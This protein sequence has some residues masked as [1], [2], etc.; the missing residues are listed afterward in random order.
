MNS[1]SIFIIGDQV[2][3]REGLRSL[4]Q[5][6]SNLNVLG[7]AETVGAALARVG[8]SEL[9]A[10]LID[11]RLPI[12][13]V[14]ATR[15]ILA[16]APSTHAIVL[17][18]YAEN[19]RLAKIIWGELRN[20]GASGLL[21]TST[22]ANELLIAIRT[23]LAGHPVF[24]AHEDTKPD[25]ALSPGPFREQAAPSLTPRQTQV[26]KLVAEGLQNKQIADRLGISSKTVEKHRQSVQEK[27]HASN[28]A[29]LTRRAIGMGLVQAVSPTIPAWS[30][31]RA[32]T[33]GPE[34]F[35]AASN[36]SRTP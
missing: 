7:E 3:A 21:P 28:A 20:V 23:V 14:D 2:I 22:P 31:K 36:E 12:C 17:S 4:L 15:R 13:A 11:L 9:N 29:D 35:G 33:V 34:R 25:P 32:P 8:R 16:S 27:L 5:F 10:V 6:G 24:P 30:P 1:I 18:R 26:F 19:P